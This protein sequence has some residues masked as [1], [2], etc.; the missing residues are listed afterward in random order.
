MNN[1]LFRWTCLLALGTL[2]FLLGLIRYDYV[3]NIVDT[4]FPFLI[5][6]NYAEQ[7]TY[8]FTLSDSWTS[9]KTDPRWLSNVIYLCYPT[10]AT[11]AAIALLFNKRSYVQL[12][13]LFYGIGVV[14]LIFLVITSILF[15]SY[16]LGYGLAQHL[17]KIYQEPY[18]SLLLLGGFYWNEQRRVEKESE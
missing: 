2:T 5:P 12:T 4:S 16:S 13:F 18:I 9:I 17:K 11:I 7:A 1:K 6:R 15:D 8:P 10:L 14:L 3:I